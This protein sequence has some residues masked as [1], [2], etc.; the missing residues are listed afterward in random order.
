[1]FVIIVEGV[2]DTPGLRLRLYPK[3]KRVGGVP[4]RLLLN[5]GS[6]LL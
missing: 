3:A 1:M 6:R 2:C 4:A 5:T